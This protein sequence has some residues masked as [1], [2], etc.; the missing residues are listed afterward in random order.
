MTDRAVH[1]AVRGLVAA[2]LACAIAAE[3]AARVVLSHGSGTYFGLLVFLPLLAAPGALVWR[4][5]QPKYLTLWALAGWLATLVWSIAGAPYQY[6]RAL[7]HWLL[8]STPVW[9]AVA[10]VQFVAPLVAAL[11]VRTDAIAPERALFALRLRRIVVL[12]FAIATIVVVTCFAFA[13]SEG[14]SVAV[15]TGAVI[16]PG[17]A[18]QWFPNRL[19]AVMWSVL[20][21]PFAGLGIWLW[22]TFGTAEHWA[23]HV[24]V[25][26]LGTIYVLV[27]LALPIICI[28]TPD[29]SVTDSSARA[30]Y[31]SRNP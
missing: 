28:V 17:F 31:R 29:R 18:V 20:C 15:Y 27:V 26:G 13:G 23:V 3:L 30:R 6:E 10:L 21:L 12:V 24:V 5:P 7:P 16:G 8:V 4:F 1:Y 22:A 19:T 14:M 11:A 25:A 9:M 2:T